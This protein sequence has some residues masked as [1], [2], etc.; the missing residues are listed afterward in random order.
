MVRTLNFHFNNAGSIP[1]GL[2]ILFKLYSEKNLKTID[3]KK[4]NFYQ[5]NF[6]FRL[7]FASLISPSLLQNPAIMSV[8]YSES[9]PRK[10]H[11]KKSYLAL[12]WFNYLNQK[13]N[14]SS[15]TASSAETGDVKDLS[16]KNS[17]KFRILPSKRSLYT[18]QKAPMAHKTN[19]KEQFMFKFYFFKFSIHVTTPLENIPKSVNSSVSAYY[20]MRSTF[21]CFETN[22]LLLKYYEISS[23]YKEKNFFNF[24]H[25]TSSRSKNKLN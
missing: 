4:F 15:H 12:S 25:F 9:L 2:K 14:K 5:K 24:H 8:S 19:S 1:A 13:T 11:L 10:I 21:P 18:F 17:L 6:I 23:L 20:I 3:F 22:L 16:S 7:H